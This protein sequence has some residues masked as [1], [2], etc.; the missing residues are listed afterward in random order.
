MSPRGRLRSERTVE[1][2]VYDRIAVDD[3][4]WIWQGGFNTKSHYGQFSVRGDDGQT[5]TLRAHR[6]VYELLVGPIPEGLT[7]DHL[8]MV[9][10]CVRPG[11]LEPV[12]Q[13]ENTRR[14]VAALG[15][16]PFGRANRA[17][18]HCKHGHEFTP[19]NT[20]RSKYGRACRACNRARTQT[21]AGA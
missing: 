4:C 6:A 8:C 18:T 15:T 5:K 19:E 16:E 21:K 10:A 12:T 14:A 1:Q 2:R 17:K 20:Y 13:R 9:K 7:L 11:H 3:G